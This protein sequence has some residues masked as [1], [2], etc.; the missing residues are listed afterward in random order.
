MFQAMSRQ[1]KRP[2]VQS[3]RTPVTKPSKSK[4]HGRSE[5]KDDESS[6]QRVNE[7]RRARG[8]KEL[9]SSI[10]IPRWAEEDIAKN[11]DSRASSRSSYLKE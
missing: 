5:T 8:I 1:P 7:N 11:K 2:P 10:R 9:P 3:L 4:H 6:M